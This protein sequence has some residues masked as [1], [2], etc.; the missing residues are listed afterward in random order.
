VVKVTLWLIKLGAEDEAAV[1]R[2]IRLLDLID[3]K[4]LAREKERAEEIKRFEEE[5]HIP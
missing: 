3:R 4:I 1:G 2:A 5:A